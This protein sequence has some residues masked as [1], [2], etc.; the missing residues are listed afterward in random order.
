MRW[1]ERDRLP[2]LFP[3]KG[4]GSPSCTGVTRVRVRM[5]VRVRVRVCVRVSACAPV[6]G[7][8]GA[9]TYFGSSCARVRTQLARADQADDCV[10]A[11][12]HAWSSGATHARTRFKHPKH[13]SSCSYQSL[14]VENSK[15]PT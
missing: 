8:R 9:Q 15:M 14:Q 10:V 12:L 11:V 1:K 2:F 7:F 6:F 4:C 13:C 5:R 3:R